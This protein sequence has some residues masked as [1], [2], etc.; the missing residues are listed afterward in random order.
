MQHPLSGANFKT[1]A[2]T[3]GHSGGIPCAHWDTVALC[4]ASA[5]ARAPLSAFED[6]WFRKQIPSLDMPAPTFIVG[7]WRSG[8]THLYNLLAAS[9]QYAYVSPL[10]TGLPWNIFTLTR[11]FR[12]LLEKALPKSRFIDNVAIRPNSPQ[13]DEIGLANMS[14]LSF[15][16]GIYCPKHFY[17][18]FNQGIFF[19]E[20]SQQSIE[21]WQK[22]LVYYLQKIYL[23]QGR[24]PLLIKNP[25]YTA[26]VSM[27]HEQFPQARFIH[28]HRNPFEVFA[29]MRNFYQK[30]FPVLALQ[31]FDHIDIETH[32]LKTYD[33]MMHTLRQALAAIPAAQRCEITYHDLD[34]QPIPTL[35]SLYQA[36][37][38][39][40]FNTH[41]TSF[42]SYLAEVKQFK[43]N[44]LS[45]DE[46]TCERIYEAW[47]PHF[48]YFG[49]TPKP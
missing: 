8:T 23:D 21:T 38:L 12:P 30:L 10:A 15:L 41:R 33:R 29:S 49:Y 6:R 3:L 27:L 18:H 34:T 16:H 19:E 7:H 11:W 9:Q 47:R 4:Y 39:P 46:A 42:E 32:I 48:E 22:T 17:K 25:V 2:K 44:A 24:R 1:L 20:V 13:E 28:I 14:E 35:E 31:R 45:L 40:H 5:I 37:N 36:L 43:K 26:R